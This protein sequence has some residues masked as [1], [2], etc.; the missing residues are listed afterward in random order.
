[1]K[2]LSTVATL[3]SWP[4]NLTTQKHRAGKFQFPVS[5]AFEFN[6][7]HLSRAIYCF[8]AF[9]ISCHFFQG[10][11]VGKN[12]ISVWVNSQILILRQEIEIY[13]PVFPFRFCIYAGIERLHPVSVVG[14][15]LL[16][17]AETIELLKLKAASL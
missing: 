4:A 13:F 17:M 9:N 1:M 14:Y 2:S 5:S 7:V 12:K 8:F 15:P 10:I 16:I 6:H 11:I 3:Y